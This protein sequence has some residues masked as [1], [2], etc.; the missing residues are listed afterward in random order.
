MKQ[1]SLVQAGFFFFLS[2]WLW[3]PSIFVSTLDLPHPQCCHQVVCLTSAKMLPVFLALH[4]RQG[5]SIPKST[6]PDT[7]CVVIYLHL[8]AFSKKTKKPISPLTLTNPFMKTP[9]MNLCLL[10]KFR[11]LKTWVY[12]MDLFTLSWSICSSSTASSLSLHTILGCWD[13]RRLCRS[14]NW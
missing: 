12:L 1:M 2:F 11:A 7:Q 14:F 5:W 9:T 13:A 6:T 3:S 8:Y 4:V 10:Q